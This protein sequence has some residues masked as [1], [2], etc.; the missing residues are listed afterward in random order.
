MLGLLVLNRIGGEVH[1]T[2]VV[3]VDQGAS[4]ERAVKLD[5]ELP[6]PGSLSH[7]VS[8][9]VVLRLGTRVG[10]DRLALVR[11]GHQVAA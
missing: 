10:D 4:G 11:P 8:D 9:S 2:D 5:E 7:A 6:E 3:A 1:R